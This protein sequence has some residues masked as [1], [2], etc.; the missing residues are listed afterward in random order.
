MAM[1]TIHDIIDVVVMMILVVVVN[2]DNK[3]NGTMK[4]FSTWIGKYIGLLLHGIEFGW[5]GETF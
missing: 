4:M 5:L 2:N 3:D 1:V